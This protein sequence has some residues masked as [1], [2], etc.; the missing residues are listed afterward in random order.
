MSWIEAFAAQRGL[1]YEA[2]V[3]ERWLRA[4]EPYTTLKVPV[5][6]RP[7]GCFADEYHWRRRR[8]ARAASGERR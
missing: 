6:R 4:W 3:D 1:R 2:D 8:T 5:V 7:G